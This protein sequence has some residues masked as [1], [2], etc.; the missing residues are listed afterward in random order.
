MELRS[1]H[2]A[3][4][5][6]ERLGLV[7]IRGD[8]GLDGRPQFGHAC[9]AGATQGFARQDPKPDFDLVEPTGGGRREMNVDIRVLGQPR[10]TFL[11]RAV[12]V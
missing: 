6:L 8:K 7:S 3:F 12:V 10:V 9:E 1:L 2:L 5:P 4:A 11:V